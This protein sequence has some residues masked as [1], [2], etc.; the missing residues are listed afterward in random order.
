MTCGSKTIFGNLERSNDQSLF[1]SYICVK[2]KDT[3]NT[4]PQKSN[5]ERHIKTSHAGF[6]EKLEQKFVTRMNN[7]KTSIKKAFI[8]DKQ[9][10]MNK[11]TQR[12]NEVQKDIV[13]QYESDVNDDM[14]RTTFIKKLEALKV[15]VPATFTKIK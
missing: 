3:Y 2:E 14:K 8:E 11:I 5:V 6:S 13:L 9:D 12:V 10:T 15:D 1:F 7:I 4:F